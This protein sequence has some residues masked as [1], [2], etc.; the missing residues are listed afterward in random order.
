MRLHPEHVA[1]DNAMAFVSDDGGAN[2][3][4]CHR[5]LRL[6]LHACPPWR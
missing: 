6:R 4:L 3:N 2:Y 1:P 5:E